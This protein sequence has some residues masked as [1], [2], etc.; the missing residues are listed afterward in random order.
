MRK[1]WLMAWS[2]YKRRIRS[3]TFLLLTFGLPLINHLN[4]F[5]I[6]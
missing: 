4:R 6:V 1:I 2:T 5:H 3:G